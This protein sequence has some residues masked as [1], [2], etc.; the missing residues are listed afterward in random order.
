M[1]YLDHF[2]RLRVNSKI[3]HVIKDR[4]KQQLKKVTNNSN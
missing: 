1:A 3:C 4:L 2:K